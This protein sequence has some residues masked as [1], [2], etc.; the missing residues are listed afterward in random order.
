MDILI[1][2]I[3]FL[4]LLAHCV[5]GLVTLLVSENIISFREQEEYNSE[6]INDEEIEV[7]TMVE[8]S[9]TIDINVCRYDATNLN[10][11]L[12]KENKI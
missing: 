8:R 10:T 7:A 6:Y 2:G 5:P 3:F 11:H 9:I 12:I 4:R 1:S